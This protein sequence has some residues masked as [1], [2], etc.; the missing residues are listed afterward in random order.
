V[1]W[2]GWKWGEKNKEE[3]GVGQDDDGLGKEGPEE[4]HWIEKDRGQG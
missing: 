2:S 4:K 1:K 3:R